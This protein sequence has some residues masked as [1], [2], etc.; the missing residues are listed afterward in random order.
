M[1]LAQAAL[2]IVEVAHAEA[3][4]HHVEVPVRKGQRERVPLNPFDGSRLAP[5]TLEHPLG[6]VEAD[7]LPAATLGLDREISGATA[8]IEHPIARP[9][10]LARREAAP[11]PVEPR[12]HRPVHHVVDRGDAVEHPAHLVGREP[13][14]LVGQDDSPQR[15]A[16]ALSIPSWS[17]QRATRKSTRSSIVSGA[18]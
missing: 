14:G 3:D 13:S 16:S 9:H 17:R 12:G 5:C 10:D 15:F 7:H 2:E 6:E 11:A 18:W 8:G 4:G 1:E